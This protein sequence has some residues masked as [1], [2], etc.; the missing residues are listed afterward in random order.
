[1]KKKFALH[2]VLIALLLSIQGFQ[3]C[4]ATTAVGGPQAPR[5]AV[6]ARGTSDSA[7]AAQSE[8]TPAKLDVPYVPTPEEVVDTMLDVA[9]VGKDDVLYDLG[10]GDGR[11]VI[12]AAK[13]RG[14]RGVGIDLNPERIRESKVNAKQQNVTNRVGFLQQDLFSTDIS[15]ATV[16]TLYLLPSVNLKL[17]PK[18]FAE[19][20]PGTRVV[21][22][23]FD[24]GEWKP[25]RTIDL[26]PHVVYF[27]VVPANVSGTWKATIQTDDGPEQCVLQLNQTYQEVE[28]TLTSDGTSM[29][30]RDAKLVGDKLRFTVI[31]N[32]GGKVTPIRFEGSI[33]GDSIEGAVMN[34]GRGKGA[35]A[36]K[37]QR[38]PGTAAPIDEEK[39]LRI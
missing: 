25:D 29:H 14:A 13:E 31:D 11:I 5:P 34:R 27:W 33:S 4:G 36:W 32:A 21:S 35:G 20:K 38:L 37:A 10:C 19:L 22:H 26:A 17:R 15:E 1:M 23:D 7:P 12:T 39:E 9:Q 2:S 18:I 8:A 6:T 3:G 28:G 30:I 24:M 16:L